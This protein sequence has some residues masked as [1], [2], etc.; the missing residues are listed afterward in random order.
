MFI[1][2]DG[3]VFFVD[4]VERCRAKLWRNN[5]SAFSRM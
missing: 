2:Y 1:S 3:R 4:I 5:I